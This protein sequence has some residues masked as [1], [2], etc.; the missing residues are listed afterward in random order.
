M[1][2]DFFVV[3]TVKFKVLGVARLSR[4]HNLVVNSMIIL[5]T[6]TQKEITRALVI[7]CLI[8]RMR[9]VQWMIRS[10]TENTLDV[11]SISTIVKQLESTFDFCTIRAV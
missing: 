3:P 6:I 8:R 5:C 4:T 9:L 11:C 2:I 7:A 10:N 1:A